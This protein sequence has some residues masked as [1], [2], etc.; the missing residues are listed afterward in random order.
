M[1]ADADKVGEL[2]GDPRRAVGWLFFS[3]GMEM[4]HIGLRRILREVYILIGRL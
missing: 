3:A 4:V 2:G 1:D